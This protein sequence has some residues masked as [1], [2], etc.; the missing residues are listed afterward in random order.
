MRFYETY[1][2]HSV[3]LKHLYKTFVPFSNSRNIA[4]FSKKLSRKL[5][6]RVM[7]TFT[8]WKVV[9]LAKR[10]YFSVWLVEALVEIRHLQKFPEVALMPTNRVLTTMLASYRS[11]S[12]D[13]RVY[14]IHTAKPRISWWSL[15][16]SQT[17]SCCSFANSIPN[18]IRWSPPIFDSNLS[19]R[20]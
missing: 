15:K 2:V 12:V 1:I 19:C 20:N 4:L 10:L 5:Q 7:E 8:F 11:Q 14:I 13:C 9:I 17:W 6:S 16:A 18:S 3:D